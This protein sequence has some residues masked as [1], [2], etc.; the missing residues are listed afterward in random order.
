ML[1][2]C[3]STP[4]AET[5]P[6]RIFVS[7]LEHSADL[8]LADLARALLTQCPQADIFGLAGPASKAA[9]VRSIQDM[10]G[11]AAMLNHAA[12]HGPEA[13]M[14]ICRLDRAFSYD[15]P[16]LAI[17]L[18][19][20][21]FHLPLARRLKSRSIPVFYYIAPQ[22]WAWAKFRIGKVRA[23]TD[24][25]ACILP[26]EEDY[27][28]SRR[29]DATYVGHPL[30][31]RLRAKPVEQERLRQVQAVGHPLVALLPG[32]RRHVIQSMLTDMLY[33][34]KRIRKSHPSARFVIPAARQDLVPMILEI[35]RKAGFEPVADPLK[36]RQIGRKEV[37]PGAHGATTSTLGQP[38][39]QVLV[40]LGDNAEILTAADLVLVAS[41]TA[42]LEVAYYNKPM[43]VCYKGSKLLYWL[44]AYWL[45]AIKHLSLVNILAG[46][47][48]VP[49]F[50]PYYNHPEAVAQE[51]IELLANEARR[52]RM[53]S[54]LAE[55]IGTL[56]RPG[57]AD[58]VAKMALDLAESRK[59]QFA[60]RKGP[61]GS[62]AGIW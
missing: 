24:K 47:R 28:R 62:N 17:L 8:Y 61:R 21:A 40:L 42:T 48:L 10:T 31:D 52:D 33:C 32:S 6:M 16:D 54:R 45:I 2:G 34:A 53:K 18:D 58:R 38:D 39:L 57:V 26:F 25:I 51:A 27:F 19:S 55:I 14:T 44:V 15:P 36:M 59:R 5:D 9:G 60:G 29:A 56:D 49:E 13:I 35:C 11:H 12:V 50:M 23:R 41:G 1:S 46:E 4:L 7:A 37:A 3:A 20:P 22:V 30:L 43:V